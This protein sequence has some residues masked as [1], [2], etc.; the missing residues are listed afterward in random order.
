MA[1][2]SQDRAG[3]VRA[4]IEA[5]P[6]S[7]VRSLEIAL[8][9]DAGGGSLSAVKSIVDVEVHDRSVRNAVFDPIIPLF[10]PRADGFDQLLFPRVALGQLWRALKVA[11][12]KACAAA[13]AA[14]RRRSESEPAPHVF[15]EL[16]KLAAGHLRGKQGEFGA[17]AEL[18]NGFRPGADLEL[19]DLIELS[20]VA[21]EALRQLPGWLAR[22]ND[23]HRAAARLM[24]KDASALSSDAGPRLVELLFARLAEPWSIL[25]IMSAFMNKPDDHY[26]AGSELAHYGAR[27]LGEIDRC[28][29]QLRAFNYEGGVAA[30]EEAAR[31]LRN[32]TAMA[33]EFEQTLTV[34]RDGPWFTR[35]AKQKQTLAGSAEAHLKKI[36]K[37]ISDALPM[38]A[39]RVRGRSGRGEP[40]VDSPPNAVA[41]ERAKA[42]L[43]FFTGARAAAA[44]GGYGSARA[45]VGEEVAHSLDAYVEELLVTLRTTEKDQLAYA[46]QYLDIAADF[47]G[48]VHDDQAAQIIR[49]RAA[50]AA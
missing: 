23:E 26:A 48:M 38:Q 16:C 46:K 43:T 31:I 44:Q 49:R 33:A 6:D 28:A 19:A 7:A 10:T 41:I 3:I 45:K 2:L 14:P 11:E 18:L 9:G 5:A 42:L 32:A 35:L 22:M 4:L 29:D 20:P 17:L 30:G 25:R 21:R 1:A 13:A 40:K 39:V 34:T 15:D 36:D 12:P 24:Y 47:A 37:A 27:I 8:G 50:A